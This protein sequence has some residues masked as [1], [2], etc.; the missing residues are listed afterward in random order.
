VTIS[1]RDLMRGLG[2]GLALAACRAPATRAPRL[3]DA[4]D[5]RDALRAAVAQVRT[6]W[7][8][9]TGWLATRERTAVVVGSDVRETVRRFTA[10]VVLRGIDGVRVVEKVGSDATPAA[11]ATFASDLAAIGP[12]RGGT[13]DPGRV[14]DHR[15]RVERDPARLPAAKWIAELD[16][17]LERAEAIG[18]SRIVWRAAHAIVDDERTWFVGEGRDV[19]QRAV[20][21]RS[22]LT[23][24]AWAGDEP[25]IGEAVGARA[26]GLEALSIDADAIALATERALE[27]LTPGQP[28]VGA[29]AVL[30]DASCVAALIGAGIGDVL[31]SQRWWRPDLRARVLLAQPIGAAAV[32]IAEDPTVGGYGGYRVDDEGWP[33][34]RTVLVDGGA[35]RR[36]LADEAGAA[37]LQVART[38]SGRR[39]HGDGVVAARASELAMMP[40]SVAAPG[41]LAALG[42]G[43]VIEDAEGVVVDPATWRVRIRARRA[44]RVVRGQLTGHA[45]S[46]IEVRGDVPG[47]LGAVRAVGD[48]V[49]V[50]PHASGL[51]TVVSDAAALDDPPA[52]VR[53]PAVVTEGDV[54]ARRHT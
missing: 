4:I 47:L 13:L 1:R 39:R 45:W 5:P 15:A 26:A 8:G 40:G 2:A 35:L 33:A 46:G 6:R 36:V 52:A 29:S 32:T 24:L 11:L 51:R 31:T 48:T 44:R 3:D 50:F 14:E 42:D 38:G 53:A 25:M 16:D 19:S 43:L 54:R 37:A 7:P 21:V 49:G 27:R 22:G 28:P 30:L 34:A 17:N 18:S 20:R 9:A 23:L 10:T 12:G 41:L